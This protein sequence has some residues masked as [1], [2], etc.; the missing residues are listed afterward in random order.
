[1]AKMR[2][3]IVGALCLVGF[4]ARAVEYGPLMEVVKQ[5]W[6]ERTHLAVI[7]DYRHSR[8]EIQALAEAA[9]EGNLITVVDVAENFNFQAV[10]RFVAR[11]IKPDYLV[12][13]RNDSMLRHGALE[14]TWVAGQLAQSGIPSIG[15]TPMAIR[16]GALFAVGEETGNEL[17]VT[18]EVKGTMHVTMPVRENLR[19]TVSAVHGKRPAASI[20]VMFLAAANH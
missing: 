19:S 17:L 2:A 6:P 11:L 4:A 16:Q 12:M 14:S 3:V 15:T 7:A 18:P 8:E 13:L 1:M 10:P 9:G 5:T 20:Q